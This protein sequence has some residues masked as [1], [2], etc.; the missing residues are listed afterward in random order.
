M[1][2]NFKEI[3]GYKNECIKTCNPTV[4]LTAFSSKAGMALQVTVVGTSSILDNGAW[5]FITR[6][7]AE[8]LRNQLNDFL[9]N[10]Y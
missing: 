3:E 9:N 6:E 2:T 10:N 7:G 5:T 1:A 8:E 4:S